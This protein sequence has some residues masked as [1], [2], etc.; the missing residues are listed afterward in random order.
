MSLVLLPA[1]NAREGKKIKEKI[2]QK[3]DTSKNG[4]GFLYYQICKHKAESANKEPNLQTRK[5]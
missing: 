1:S 2:I 4:T 5:K 3:S